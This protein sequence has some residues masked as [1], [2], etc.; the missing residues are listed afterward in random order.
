MGLEPKAH[1]QH[2]SISKEQIL[3]FNAKQDFYPPRIT[4]NEKTKK[5]LLASFLEGSGKQWIDPLMA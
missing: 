1:V 3:V 4:I 5:G 2:L